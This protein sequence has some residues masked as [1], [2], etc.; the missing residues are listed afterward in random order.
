V[1]DVGPSVVTWGA[2]RLWALDGTLSRSM[3]NPG[4]GLVAITA[5]GGSICSWRC[6][7]C[8][9]VCGLRKAR[10]WQQGE[11]RADNRPDASQLEPFPLRLY[12]SHL[13]AAET[14]LS[15]VRISRFKQEFFRSTQGEYPSR[16]LTGLRRAGPCRLLAAP[17]SCVRSA[18]GGTGALYITSVPRLFRKYK[19]GICGTDSLT[20]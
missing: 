5:T 1:N 10:A 16:L 3:P 18:F 17:T 14:A 15:R 9:A 7:R 2:G 8:G 20:S 13:T 19:S 12:Q 11:N 6:L 4:R